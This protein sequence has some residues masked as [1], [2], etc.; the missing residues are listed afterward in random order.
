MV[1]Y[2]LNRIVNSETMV[3][4]LSAFPAWSRDELILAL[5]LYLKSH[6]MLDDTS[7]EVIEL[8]RLLNKLPIHSSR[9]EHERFRNPNS[10]HMKLANFAAIDPQYPGKGLQAVGKLDR[11]IWN[12]YHDKPAEV[13][14]LA[15]KIRTEVSSFSFSPEDD[16]EEIAEGRLLYRLHRSRERDPR[17]VRKKKA[18]VLKATGHLACE[19]CGFDFEMTYGEIGKGFAECHHKTSLSDTGP[20]KTRLKDLAIVCPNCHRILHRV[21]PWKMVEELRETI[22]I[23]THTA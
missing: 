20:T 12:R 19:A 10:V 21:R 22:R 8:S 17:I 3:E 13:S 5:D 16:E 6:R 2:A 7:E 23:F 1:F 14:R 4:G 11:E 15:N 9:P 18:I